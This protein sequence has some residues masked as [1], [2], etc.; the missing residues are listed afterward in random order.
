MQPGRGRAP[1]Q[2]GLQFG[3]RYPSSPFETVV[4]DFLP[5]EQ[6]RDVLNLADFCGMLAFDKW[7]CNTNGR[8]AIFFRRRIETRYEAQMIDQGFCFNAGVWNFPDAPLRGLYARHRVYEGVRGMESFEP[9][10]ARIERFDAAILEEAA[11]EIPPEWYGGESEALEKLL[12]RLLRRRHL[13]PEPDRFGLEVV[14]A[15]FSKLEVSH[16]RSTEKYV[17]VSGVALHAQ[18]GSRRMGEHRRPVGR[19]AGA[20]LPGGFTAGHAHHRTAIGDCPGQAL[21]SRRRR[22]IAARASPRNSRRGCGSPQTRPGL[23]SQNSIR[24]CRM[25]CSSAR[26]ERC[27]P[28]I[29]TPNSTACSTITS[30]PRLAGGAASSRAHAPGSSNASTMYCC[31]GACR[32][33]NAI[34]PWNSS[35]NRETHCGSITATVTA[36]AATCTRWRLAAIPRSRKFWPTPPGASASASPAAN[37]PPSP[38]RS[39]TLRGEQAT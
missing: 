20:R 9:W 2:E 19:T 18:C 1:C 30:R 17:P 16:G 13:V 6:L 3:S 10:I 36:C 15:T 24:A 5:D 34:F 31:G 22:A 38:R 12:E 7:T 4:Y 33:L 28:P 25:R 39:Q 23:I 21:A 26:N 32:S 29:S 37:S 27:W 11:S 14:G 35:P 8:Q